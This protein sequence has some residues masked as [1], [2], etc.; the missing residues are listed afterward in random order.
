M[1]VGDL[2]RLSILDYPQYRGKIGVLVREHGVD[3]WRVYIAG[4]THPYL[5]HGAA[6]LPVAPLAA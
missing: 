5:V 6:A 3:R 2:V 4:R 1:K